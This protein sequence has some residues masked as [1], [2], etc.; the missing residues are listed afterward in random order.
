M[1]RM[2]AIRIAICDDH[3]VFRTGMVSV[4]NEH[5][6]FDVRIEVGS[7]ADL[8]EALGNQ[9][10]DVILLDIELP[11]Q[12]GLE[13]LPELAQQYRVL[14]FSAFDDARRVKQAMES[15]A[16]G[17]VRKDADS[18]DLISSLREAAA[19]RTVLDNELAMRVAQSLRSEPDSVEF[20][21]KVAE[22]TARQREVVKL[23]AQGKSN[24]EISKML[25]VSEGTVNNHVT[26]ILQTLQVPDRTKLAVLL[27]R[28][29]VE[30]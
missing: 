8:R 10:V 21:R 4:L 11:G 17:F 7:V 2:S 20:R 27:L 5:E 9:E 13:A 1:A 19:G 6:E 28:Y 12:S 25:F 3:P 18:T 23:L 14:V 26:R 15:G 22:L 29:N 16:V 30:L 24:R